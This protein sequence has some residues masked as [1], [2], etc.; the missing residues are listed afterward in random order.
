MKKLII[1]LLIILVV[2]VIV[3]V[4]CVGLFLDAG[5]KKGVETVG[6][7][8]TKVDVKLDSASLSLLSG[9]GKLTGLVVG[10]PEG[11]KTPSAINLGSVSL[12]IKPG[13]LFSDKVV[14]RSINIQAP[15]ITFET[16]LKSSNLKKIL[17]NLEETSGGGSGKAKTSTPET[18]K[19]ANK[20]LEVDEFV[21]SGAKVN[22]NISSMVGKAATVTIPEI[23]LTDLGTGPEGITV[24]ELSKRI[25]NV[26]LEN[27]G[28]AAASGVSDL[29]KSAADLTKDLGKGSTGGVEKITKGLGDLLKKPK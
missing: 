11:F 10:N 16:D 24:A 7:A 17:A 19:K 25:L 1:R 4:V 15:E 2:L 29:S 14:I 26:L 8:I 21:I 9:S 18:E 23:R 20:K 28:K 5:V 6:S 13:S 27:S 22:V 12:S 3:A